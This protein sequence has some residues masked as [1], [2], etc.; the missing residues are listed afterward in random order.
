ME[1]LSMLTIG[2]IA[3][4]ARV[5][6]ARERLVAAIATAQAG[7]T[8]GTREWPLGIREALR[9]SIRQ[10]PIRNVIDSEVDL[11]FSD[12]GCLPES[13]C[14]ANCVGLETRKAPD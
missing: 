4:R 1:A 9:P 10:W 7:C 3:L 13:L 12:Y 5:Q 2:N 8:P 11:R 14:Y 6:G